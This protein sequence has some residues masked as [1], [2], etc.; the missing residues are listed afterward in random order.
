M[1]PATRRVRGIVMANRTEPAAADLGCNLGD[2]SQPDE[3]R[4]GLG[5]DEGRLSSLARTIEREVIPRLVLAHRSPTASLPTLTDTLGRL[6]SAQDVVDLTEV[7]LR[8]GADDV[9][10]FVDRV[11]TQGVALE[12]VFL[13][14]LAPAARRLGDLWTDD[15]CDFTQ[16]TLG[17]W[18]LQCVLHDLSPAFESP[19]S[20][21]SGERR[22]MLAPMPGEQHS[23]GLEMVA[24]FFRRAQWDVLDGP[25][26]TCGELVDLVSRDWFA[27]VGISACAERH[28]EALRI[29]IRDV[30]RASRNSALGIIVG[31]VIFNEHP[32][33]VQT[34][35]A[36]ATAP[37]GPSAVV[38]A[39]SLLS[40]QLRRDVN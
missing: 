21:N 10:A 13:H 4:S 19:A 6:P 8:Q 22:I 33:L 9:M 12:S 3:V 11:R 37:D 20:G 14:L 38:V 16:V 31:G 5:W 34:V 40:K 26:P 28:L 2:T 27:M 25:T 32:E 24:E 1:L 18:R 17:L 15:R 23:F 36:D 30:R 39:Q 29:L 35:G 7:V